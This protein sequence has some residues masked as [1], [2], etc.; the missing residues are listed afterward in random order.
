M[1]MTVGMKNVEKNVEKAREYADLLPMSELL[2]AC[3]MFRG[4]GLENEGNRVMYSILMAGATRR[5]GL[6][7]EFV[8][9]TTDPVECL[10]MHS[11]L[12]PEA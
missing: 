1:T 7:P 4:M 8:A 6:R 9:R 12:N 11:L 3:T 2:S 5:L 10:R